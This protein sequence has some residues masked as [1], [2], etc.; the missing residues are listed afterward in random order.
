MALELTQDKAKAIDALW[1]TWES[2]SL[3]IAS[4]ETELEATFQNL[5]YTKFL[6]IIKTLRSL[7]LRE[8]M[9]PPRLN[10]MVSGGMRFTITGD[11]NI[12]AYCNTNDLKGKPFNVIMKTRALPSDER[13]DIDIEDYNMR[14]K[15]RREQT[16][17][18]KNVRVLSLLKTWSTQLKTF[19]YI[20]RY[21]F[22]STKFP[23]LRFDASFVRQ[24]AYIKSADA[25][26]GGFDRTQTFQQANLGAQPLRFEI[27]V[28]AIPGHGLKLKE[29][30]TGISYVLRGI[31]NSYVIVRKPVQSRVLEMLSK[32][33]RTRPGTFPGALPS[34]F[35]RKNMDVIRED[36]VPNIRYTDYNCT[37]KADGVRCILVVDG[38][39]K[40]Y[41]VDRNLNVIATDRQLNAELATEWA[42]TIL[43]GEWVT[44]DLHGNRV[45]RYYAF[46]IFNSKRGEDVTM[47][48]FYIRTS[49]P[50]EAVVSRLAALTEACKSLA[51]AN[52]VYKGVPVE[53]SFDIR[54]KLFYM[55]DNTPDVDP[56]GIFKKAAEALRD[57]KARAEYHTDGLIFTPN[58]AP[59]R[60]FGRWDE[61]LKWKPAEMNS[62]DF[63]VS[64]E[65]ERDLEG[66][67]V[68]N[69]A[70]APR[71][72]PDTHQEVR[73]KTMYLYV[74]V[75]PVNQPRE[76]I[77]YRMDLPRAGEQ[78][79]YRPA[80]F[81][82]E[83]TDPM[84]SVSYIAINPGATD[85]AAAAPAA[86]IIPSLSDVSDLVY[87]ESGDHIPDR[88]IVEM[89]YD[90]TKP[91]GW[92][93]K[94][95]RVRWDKTEQF[96]RGEIGGTLNNINTAN[97]VWNSIHDPVTE[98]MISTGSTTP[99]EYETAVVPRP[100]EVSKT[101]Y[102]THR[103]PEYDLNR[104]R[105]MTAFHNH[106]IKENMLLHRVIRPGNSLLDMSVGQAGDLHKWIAARVGFVLGCDIASNGIT[107]KYNG[108]YA[109]YMNRLIDAQKTG[110]VIPP[111]MF[112]CADSSKRY[113]DGSAG[114]EEID[115]QILRTIY[116]DEIPS[117]PPLAKQYKNLGKPQFPGFDVCAIM[118]ALH[119]FFSDEA[120]LNGLLHNIH[121]SLKVGGYFIGCCFD[122]DS[123]VR[124]LRDRRILIGESL[125]GI[126]GDSR[127]WSIT[128]QYEDNELPATEEGLGKKIDVEFISIGQKLSEYLVSWNFLQSK[129]AS[130]GLELLNDE[131]L[132][133]LG[134]DASS[135]TFKTSYR[136][137]EESG[138]R[139]VMSDA[140]K[141]F[142]FLNRWF[143]FRRRELKNTLP[144]IRTLPPPPPQP[145]PIPSA[146]PAVAVAPSTV[147]AVIASASAAPLYEIGFEVLDKN[148]V[149][150]V[151][152]GISEPVIVVSGP[153]Q[154]ESVHV[155]NVDFSD[156]VSELIYEYDLAPIPGTD[157]LRYAGPRSK[158]VPV[159]APAIA[160]PAPV[161]EEEEE[162]EE[163]MPALES[164]EP[165]LEKATG[166]IFQFY[167]K[168]AAKDDLGIKL[169]H[170]RR[171]LSPYTPFT[172]HDLEDPSII[173]PSLEAAWYGS[174][175]LLA[176][177]K[178]GL[179]GPMFSIESNTHQTAAT[180][181]GETA[182]NP[183]QMDSYVEEGKKYYEL[184]G[185]PAKLKRVGIVFNNE[186]WDSKKE[187]VMID[188]LKQRYVRDPVFK[189]I[190]DA[191]RAKKAH[192]YFYS[193]SGKD[194]ELSGTVSDDEINGP[195]LLGRGIMYLAGLRY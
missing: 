105:G 195:N 34:T 32:L 19:R 182:F 111:M 176:S 192:V 63:L 25:R 181:R 179:R 102:Y 128:K 144:E 10:I 129:L 66:R 71:I 83:M 167:H 38:S 44:Q 31:Q 64:F 36:G 87:C 40:L 185:T 190:I 133:E 61:Q 80:R 117:A 4:N 127:I 101:V 15:L 163:E 67:L 108:A 88:S 56:L 30:L 33:T 6:D 53:Q 150:G 58:A 113:S 124:L 137:A 84:A 26:S 98:Y 151:V 3:G 46:D 183:E 180:E 160:A 165:V 156:G 79:S 42:G 168:S 109:R 21:S 41:M 13:A 57:V 139:F 20:H 22:Y 154:G 8:E 186:L 29:F 123:V 193:I 12:E 96:S 119:Y 188:L 140:Q 125:D 162:E 2:S 136:M 73:C 5:N 35:E 157:R 74:G 95:M 174:R 171:Y 17:S 187:Q 39:G 23:G 106:Y 112:V 48:P 49:K 153:H 65:K 1:K 90:P 100:V 47:R 184:I 118:F 116:G 146:T 28:E 60:K 121:E 194:H 103:A 50:D 148:G 51:G 173:Y 68:S 82:P 59:L 159:T 92:R 110:A 158:P 141:Q 69:D 147:P 115:R 86:R 99:S 177:N 138:K 104:I 114:L 16:L 107:E 122:G 72:H 130:I 178:P 24:S 170:W 11:A 45:S 189:Q 77:L 131:E 134:L 55:S 161:S 89:S 18:N 52:R 132:R 172:F 145:L 169:K 142:S 27:E 43:D 135:N 37:D 97:N 191:I 54:Q 14:I 120:T 164:S 94:P 70:V 126:D 81:M 149:V 155:Y 152:S 76:T 91:A 175:I 75:N 7:G 78:S 9:Q 143:I 166:P 62:I 85:T 93:W